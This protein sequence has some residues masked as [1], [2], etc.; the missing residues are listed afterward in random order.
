MTDD[1]TLTTIRVVIALLAAAVVVALVTRRLRV[2]Y[3]VGLVLLGAYLV[4]DALGGSGIIATT[5][6]GVTLGGYG[7]L[8]G[9]SARAANSIDQV[10]EFIAFV[11]TALIFMLVGLAIDLG[12]LLSDIVPIAWAVLAIL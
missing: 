6:A 12:M 2:P 11:L 4:A 10:W 9:L 8:H 1:T 7:R 5:V 3:T